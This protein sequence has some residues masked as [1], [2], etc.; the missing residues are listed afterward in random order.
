MDVQDIRYPIYVVSKGRWDNQ[1]TGKMFE[2]ENIPFKF[3]VEP[4]E[5]QN[6][7]EALGV[8]KVL[9]LPFSNLGLGSFP[10][11]NWIWKHSIESGF[12]KHWIFDDNIRVFYRS[13]KGI[14]RQMSAVLAITSWEDF[15]SRYSNVAISG[16]NYDYF[17]PRSTKKPFQ[18]NCHVYSS[19]LIR[20]DIPFRWRLKYNEDVDL[21]LQVLHNGW[22]TMLCN[23]FTVKKTSTSAKMKGGNQTELYQNNAFEKKVLKAKTL[24]EMWPQYVKTI[25]RFN[26]PHHNVNWKKHFNHPLLKIKT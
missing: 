24:E 4:Q 17:V 22:C 7:V 25:W 10:A 23:A 5:Y 16:F 21:C 18:I 19:L 13:N 6:Y 14:R 15:V 8:G 26:R 20:N 9:K 11:R 2:K 12:E 1:L 3:V